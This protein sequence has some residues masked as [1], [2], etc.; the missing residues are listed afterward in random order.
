[1]CGHS[2]IEFA[3]RALTASHVE[4]RD[5][6]EVGARDVNGSV[7]P[8][9]ESLRPASYLGVDIEHGFRVDEL[10]PVESLVARYGSNRF[11]V[12]IATELVEHVRDWRAGFDNMKRVL[13][14]GGV[15]L[16]TTRSKGFKVHGYPYDFWR[17]ELADIRVILADFS[18]DTVEPDPA[19]PGVF[20]LA[21]KPLDWR[22]QDLEGVELY[23][24]VVRRRAREITERQRLAFMAFYRV[25]QAYRRLLPETVRARIKRAVTRRR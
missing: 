25:H 24:V 23:S 2:A 15:L 20:A 14:P 5:V 9:V 7:R 6:L 16:V 11:H 21:T 19:V 18:I 4:G 8:H 3:S 10:C 17:Y 13:R 22:P 1:V 12:V